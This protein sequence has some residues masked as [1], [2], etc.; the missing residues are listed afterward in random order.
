MIVIPMAG[1]SS[2]FF[3]AGYTVPKYQLQL[4]AN[5]V[6]YHVI[7]SFRYYFDSEEFLFIVNDENVVRFIHAQAALLGIRDY[8]IN[9]LG[10]ATAGQA[11]TVFL[12][13]QDIDDASIY[14]FNI[15]T[16]RHDY[17][18]PDFIGEV[19]GYLEVFRDA[20]GHWSFVD[21][22]PDGTVLRTT[23]KERIS[24][25]CSD[26]LYYFKSKKDFDTVFLH[27]QKN[28]L[29]TRGEL[30]VAPL[31]NALIGAGKDIRYAVAERSC[32]DLCGTPDEYVALIKKYQADL[33]DDVVP[34][35][36][37][38]MPKPD[39]SAAVASFAFSPI[40][41]NVDVIDLQSDLEHLF[42]FEHFP[43]YA[44][45]TGQPREEDL[46]SALS[47][48]ISKGSGCVQLDK[49]IPLDILYAANHADVVG[50]IWERHHKEFARFIA[51]LAP[52]SVL[53][54]GGA[55]GMLCKNSKEFNAALKWTIVEPNPIPRDDV[56]AT[57][58]RAFFD[59]SFRSDL[60][61]DMVVHSHTLEHSYDPQEF[62]KNIGGFL[63]E[64]AYHVFSIPDIEAWL[65]QKFTNALNFEHTYLLNDLYVTRLL[66]DNGFRVVRKQTF[67]DRHSVFYAAI[68]DSATTEKKTAYPSHLF[69]RNVRLLQNYKTYLENEIATLNARLEKIPGPVYLFGAHVFS[70]TLIALGLDTRKIACIIDN[71]KAKQGKR[72][73]GTGLSVCAAEVLADQQAPVVIIRAGSYNEE[74]KAGIWEAINPATVF[75]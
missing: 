9:N 6:F 70:Q 1:Q 61:C 71:S 19:D 7:N 2:R 55:H 69:E 66:Q 50:G 52:A 27:A 35:N 33:T 75:I 5:S 60:Q 65:E 16:I 57:Y 64:N 56:D 42:S 72:L 44:G 39:P 28:G 41:R 18:K 38:D 53:E 67:G 24:D 20:G 22:G 21:P 26:G 51:D 14:I 68:K 11:E 45:C 31:Y 13:M 10:R 8:R 32:L 54:I 43:V 4:G 25:L 49:L 15:D 47:F 48:S 59:A 29:T 63:A 46:F 34:D 58:I 74:I 40:I 73:Y 36:P 3:N 30:Y 17:R 12:G 62:V 37:D 23:E